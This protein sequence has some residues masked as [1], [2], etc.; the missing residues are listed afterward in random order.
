MKKIMAVVILC[1]AGLAVYQ[2]VHAGN[3]Y[4]KDTMPLNKP[5]QL[6]KDA[7]FAGGKAAWNSFVARHLNGN[8]PE[9]KEPLPAAIWWPPVLL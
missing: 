7:V 2:P 4:A 3:R 9:I 5:P 8:V 6:E 1:L